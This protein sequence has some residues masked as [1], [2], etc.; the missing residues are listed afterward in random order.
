MSLVLNFTMEIATIN[1]PTILIV[2]D[3]GSNYL[4]YEFHLKSNY[5][6]IHACTGHE[7]IELFRIHTPDL[8]L[9]DIKLPEL[10]GYKATKEIRKWSA[11]VPIIAVTAYAFTEDKNK[12]LASGFNAYFAKPVSIEILQN[13]IAELLNS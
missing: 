3:D 12:I 1:Q 2:E 8:I 5:R 11:T 4:L 6:I 9:M 13:K 7:A 10:N